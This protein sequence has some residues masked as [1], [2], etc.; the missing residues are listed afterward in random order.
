[1]AGEAEVLGENPPQGHFVHHK[2]HLT[3]PGIEPRPPRWEARTIRCEILK[4]SLCGFTALVDLGR[5]FSFLI[6]T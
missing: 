1:M 6:Y 3:R 4:K 5:F 2:S